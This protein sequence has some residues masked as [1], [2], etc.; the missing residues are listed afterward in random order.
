MP[1]LKQAPS[2]Y[3]RKHF[4][5]STQPMEEPE[6]PADLID[7]MGWLGWD[8]ILFASDYPHWDAD[9]PD[10]ALPPL[11]PKAIADGIYYENARRVHRLP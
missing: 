6:H 7:I 11:V 8:R 9:N 5:V 1:H 2:E 3:M 10:M 4:W